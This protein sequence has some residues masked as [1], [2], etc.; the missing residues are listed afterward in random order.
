M[1]FLGLYDGF[2]STGPHWRT[3]ADL[4]L[5]P[6]VLTIIGI[7]IIL[8]LLIDLVFYKTRQTGDAPLD[9]TTKPAT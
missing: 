8:I 3:A 6:I 5:V 1:I 7:L 9:R 2:N 4:P